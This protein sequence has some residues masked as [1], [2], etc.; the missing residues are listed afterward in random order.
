M[1]RKK[2]AGRSDPARGRAINAS[3][4]SELAETMLDAAGGCGHFVGAGSQELLGAQLHQRVRALFA[5]DALHLDRFSAPDATQDD[6]LERWFRLRRWLGQITRPPAPGMPQ[7]NMGI[8]G[9]R[10]T[11]VGS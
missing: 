10:R 1:I 8:L 3:S 5:G 2:G 11:Q 4:D 7:E 9:R 6:L